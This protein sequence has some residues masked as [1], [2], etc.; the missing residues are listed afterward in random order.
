M[1]SAVDP[2]QKNEVLAL[3]VNMLISWQNLPPVPGGTVEHVRCDDSGPDTGDVVCVTG[4]HDSLV[5]K[6]R[7]RCLG[8]NDICRY[9]LGLLRW[10]HKSTVPRSNRK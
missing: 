2:A 8:N 9:Q 3:Y 4:Q 10:T 6:S 7:G 1:Q 5:T